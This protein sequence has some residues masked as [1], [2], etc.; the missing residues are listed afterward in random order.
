MI[1]HISFKHGWYYYYRVHTQR[2]NNL[3]KEFNELSNYLLSLFE[4]CP[5]DYFQTYPRGSAIKFKHSIITEYLNNHEISEWAKLS[6]AYSNRYK[7][8][9]SRIEVFMLENDDNTLAVEVPLW[10]F[11]NEAYFY[12]KFFNTDNPLTG[13]IDLLRFSENKIW[14]WDYKPKAQKE[15]YATLQVL[16]YAYMLSKRTNINLDNFMCGYF[17]EKDTYI[18]KPRVELFDKI[19]PSIE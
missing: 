12:N 8:A 17:D 5:H 7:A 9:H 11:P 16:F 15:K 6:V 3:P 2:I 18:F 4:S 13:H 1:K 10:L 14:I 19:L